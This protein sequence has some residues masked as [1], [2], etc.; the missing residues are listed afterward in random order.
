[1]YGF[2]ETAK[3]WFVSSA[4]S[5]VGIGLED[6]R[7]HALEDVKDRQLVVAADETMFNLLNKDVRNPN[8]III[9]C[10]EAVW[11]FLPERSPERGKSASHAGLVPTFIMR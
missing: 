2:N 5:S 7:R 8:N 1:M 11:V 3:S 6:A 10:T 9:S 4:S